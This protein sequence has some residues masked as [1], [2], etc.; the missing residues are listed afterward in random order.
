MCGTRY[1]RIV[2][3]GVYGAAAVGRGWSRGL[4][5]MKWSRSLLQAK[6]FESLSPL[7]TSNGT[8]RTYV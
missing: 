7:H 1:N 4:L 6:V 3:V 2:V 5:R 8:K